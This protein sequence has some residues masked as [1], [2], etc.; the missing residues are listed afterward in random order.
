MGGKY[1]K[2]LPLKYPTS[3]IIRLWLVILISGKV[4]EK[5]TTSGRPNLSRDLEPLDE[6]R[7]RKLVHDF[8]G[9]M[10]VFFEAAEY[11]VVHIMGLDVANCIL[12]KVSV[13][14]LAKS[15]GK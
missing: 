14:W 5:K 6:K 1:Q 4:L 2:V 12:Y 10:P 8:T 3:E 9:G 11:H 13:R 7:P 15:S